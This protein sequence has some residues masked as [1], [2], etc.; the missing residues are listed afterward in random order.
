[1]LIKFIMMNVIGN[2]RKNKTDEYSSLLVKS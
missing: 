1:M 2:T